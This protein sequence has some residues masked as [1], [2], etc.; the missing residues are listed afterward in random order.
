MNGPKTHQ[1]YE[2]DGFR[3]DAARRLLL[4]SEGESIPLTPRAFDTLS[5]TLGVGEGEFALG[6]T[7]NFEAY[8]A[9]LAGTALL[10][11]LG[12]E[13]TLWGLEQL[14][15]AVAMD[16]EFANAWS[17]LAWGYN[18]AANNFVGERADEFKD[19]SVAAVSRAVAVAPDAAGSH[20]AA[21]LLHAVNRDWVEAERS[22]QKALELASAATLWDYDMGVLLLAVGRARDAIRHFQQAARTESLILT[23][24]MMVGVAYEFIGDF[25]KSLEVFKRGEGLVIHRIPRLFFLYAP[26]SYPAQLLSRHYRSFSLRR[27]C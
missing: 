8:D 6:G 14:E 9:Y 4:S 2:F 19:K 13:N 10:G 25:E 20:R 15:E 17:A 22:M 18:Y 3:L 1:V 12:R 16:P 27:P 26:D 7:D 11:Q 5:I 23:P 24:V 21:A